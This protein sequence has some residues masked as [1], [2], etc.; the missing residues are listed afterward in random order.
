MIIFL[1][2]V[3]YGRL[4]SKAS[5]FSIDKKLSRLMNILVKVYLNKSWL[6]HRYACLIPAKIS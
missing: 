6:Y 4:M 1:S 3:R 2:D 5:V